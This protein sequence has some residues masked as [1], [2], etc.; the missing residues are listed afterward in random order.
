MIKFPCQKI[1][2]NFTVNHLLCSKK[3]K[4]KEKMKKGEGS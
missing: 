3:E 4:K 1:M 2:K